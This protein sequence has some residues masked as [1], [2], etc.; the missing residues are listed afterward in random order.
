MGETHRGL[1]DAML[2]DVEK[3]QSVAEEAC[4]RRA[5]KEVRKREGGDGR[6]GEGKRQQ[7]GAGR[8]RETEGARGGGMGDRS[9]R[10][11]LDRRYL[12]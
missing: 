6:G 11:L 9:A 3:A 2:K 12:W 5:T 8:R 10:E 1:V 7:R 4:I